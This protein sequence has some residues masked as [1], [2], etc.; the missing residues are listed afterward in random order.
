MKKQKKED[1]RGRPHARSS[2]LAHPDVK[3]FCEKRGI[4]S[5]GEKEHGTESLE[6]RF[7]LFAFSP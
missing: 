5:L 7:F 4:D 6:V 1:A 3:F 2:F